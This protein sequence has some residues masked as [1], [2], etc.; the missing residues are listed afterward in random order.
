MAFAKQVAAHF[1]PG[2]T[3]AINGD[4]PTEVTEVARSFISAFPDMQVF[5]DVVFNEETVEYHWTFTGTNAGPG[6]T[7]KAADLRLRGMDV[8]RRGPRRRVARPLRPGRERPPAR[9]R[10]ARAIAVRLSPSQ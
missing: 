8:R 5:M 10:G 2:G 1:V 6:G 7:G 3:I 4:E 9:A